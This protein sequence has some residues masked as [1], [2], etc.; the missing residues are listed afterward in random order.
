LANDDLPKWDFAAEPQAV[1]VELGTNDFAPGVPD[2]EFTGAYI[3]FVRAIRGRY[4]HALIVCTIGP[5]MSDDYPAG[6]NALS[7][8]R[9]YIE[10]VVAARTSDGDANIALFEFGMNVDGDF[11][12]D[13]HPNVAKQQ[14]MADALGPWLKQ[15]LGW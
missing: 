10:A 15:K 12:C 6:Q 9:G 14:Q 7:T 1:I 13:Y 11:G 4:P 8:I 2:D 5:M 3:D